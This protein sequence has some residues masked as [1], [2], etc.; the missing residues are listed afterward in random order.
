VCNPEYTDVCRG[1]VKN[2]FDSF[3]KFLHSSKRTILL[4][5]ITAVMTIVVNT[6]ISIW[7]YRIVNVN[8]PSLGTIKTLGVEAYWDR[9]LENKTEIIDWGTIWPGSSK[10]ATFYVRSISNVEAT[11]YLH[12]ANWN[13]ANLSDHVTLSWNYNGTTVHP[14]E[15]IQVTLTLSAPSSHPF[16]LYLITNDVKEFSFDIIIGASEYSG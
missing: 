1:N 15:I 14:G 9:N 13:P 16:I 6:V 8:I 5:L 10:N 12:T 3:V 7:L 2:A 11:L 4:I